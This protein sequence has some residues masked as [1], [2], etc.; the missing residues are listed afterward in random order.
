MVLHF[1]EKQT[2]SIRSMQ[3]VPCSK[4]KAIMV[5]PRPSHTDVVM[6]CISKVMNLVQETSEVAEVG[7]VILAP[8]VIMYYAL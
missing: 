6:D 5:T 4:S 3:Q 1:K 2:P 8:T 7:I